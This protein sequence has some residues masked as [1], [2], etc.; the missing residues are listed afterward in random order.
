MAPGVAVG[1]PTTGAAERSITT[2]EDEHPRSQQLPIV[3][4]PVRTRRLGWSLGINDVRPKTCSYSCV[5]CQVGATT[6]ARS[7]RE[8]YLEPATIATAVR[9]RIKAC[10]S[11]G[12]IVDFATFVPDGEPT[13]DIHLGETIRA[14]RRPDLPVAVITN[15]SLL[16]RD[17][18][19]QE[20]AAADWVSVK[21]DTVD[22]L[23]WRRLNRPI[24]TLDLGVVLEG[25]RRFAKEYRGFLATET[26][27]VAGVNDD[28]AAVRR[29]ARFVGSLR[30][31]HA[32][33]TVPV[34]PGTE[35]WV[36]GPPRDVA[37]AAAEDFARTGV[38]ATLLHPDQAEAGFAQPDEAVEGLIGILAVQPMTER[39][40]QDYVAASAADWQAVEE[41]IDA[42]R[43]VRVVHHGT[44][45]LRLDHSHRRMTGDRDPIRDRTTKR[46]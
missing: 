40:A 9:D 29:V 37:L 13:L 35:P 17:D 7:R 38:Q 44:A 18:V 36:S 2:T 28:A 5:Y 41:L 46:R 1:G 34:R 31:H 42:G 24:R 19:R 27:L 4:G 10:R 3:F 32:Y 33:I 20:L 12:Q 22:E 30:P 43:I 15:A 21:V 11:S 16:W 6:R 23:I 25:V 14:I 45:Y 26:M 8:P 39:A